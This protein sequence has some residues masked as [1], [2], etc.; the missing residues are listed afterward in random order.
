MPMNKH[1]GQVLR[2]QTLQHQLDKG[3][4]NTWRWRNHNPT[5]FD[6]GLLTVNRQIQKEA[7]NTLL[8]INKIT[9]VNDLETKDT[10]IQ[11]RLK[12]LLSQVRDLYIEIP[13]IDSQAWYMTSLASNTDLKKINI[14]I[15]DD[16]EFLIHWLG[17]EE[18][19]KEELRAYKAIHATQKMTMKYDPDT[20]FMPPMGIPEDELDELEAEENA[21]QDLC[22]EIDEF[23]QD[24]VVAKDD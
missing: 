7:L 20:L 8:R 13:V 18:K 12:G 1:E 15:K 14:Q 9:V 19:A 2:Q 6:C 10:A 21:N 4:G 16:R 24:E 17:N 23:I 11:Q 3:S 22:D 5:L